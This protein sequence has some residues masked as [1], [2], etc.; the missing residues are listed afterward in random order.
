MKKRYVI[1]MLSIQS[2]LHSTHETSLSPDL[3]KEHGHE[4]SEYDIAAHFNLIMQP[5]YDFDEP[6]VLKPRRQ[7]PIDYIP[8]FLRTI[9]FA[10]FRKYIALH[11]TAQERFVKL[12][13]YLRRKLMVLKWYIA[14]IGAP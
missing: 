13:W 12:K 3:A 11:S 14:G 6:G 7:Q 10:L 2:I 4:Q 5:E 8:P 9:G 1:L